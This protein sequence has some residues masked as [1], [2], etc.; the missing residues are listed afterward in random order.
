MDN[1]V[2]KYMCAAGV[3]AFLVKTELAQDFPGLVKAV[4]S[5]CSTTASI[6]A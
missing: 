4:H 2:S 1:T 3:A 5:R 6:T